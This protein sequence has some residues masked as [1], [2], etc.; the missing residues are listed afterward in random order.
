M[1]HAVGGLIK[2]LRMKREV[3]SSE[4]PLFS[5]NIVIIIFLDLFQNLY[6]LLHNLPCCL[7][8]TC[9]LDD[10]DSVTKTFQG[11]AELNVPAKEDAIVTID[12]NMGL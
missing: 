2:F 11:F 6:L 10:K 5:L 1:A 8:F 7:F 3:I 12:I 4:T 9:E